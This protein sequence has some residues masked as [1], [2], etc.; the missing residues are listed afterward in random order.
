[1]KK[2]HFWFS[3]AAIA[4]ITVGLIHSGI[5][6]IVAEVTWE[7]LATSFPTWG[8]F[9]LTLLFYA[10]GEGVILLAWLIT[11]LIVRAVRNNRCKM[12]ENVL[13]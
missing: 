10:M 13:R 12:W 6:W 5:S 4:V 3:V 1:M 7:P 11:W 2:L 8:A 9:V